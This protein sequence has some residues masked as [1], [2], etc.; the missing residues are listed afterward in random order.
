ML[1]AEMIEKDEH[2]ARRKG[3]GGMPRLL[4]V[5]LSTS[6]AGRRV[7]FCFQ[8]SRRLLSGGSVANA[9]ERS[10]CEFGR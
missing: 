10:G 4:L 6:A 9:T 8:A 7:D 5:V 2:H 1:L 3:D